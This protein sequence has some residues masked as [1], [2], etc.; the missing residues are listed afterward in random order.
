LKKLLTYLK[1]YNNIFGELVGD[2]QTV[3]EINKN[4]Y[5]KLINMTINQNI[6]IDHVYNHVIHFIVDMCHNKIDDI[7]KKIDK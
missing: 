7:N 3:D 1:Y 6:I 4:I 5:D 2:V